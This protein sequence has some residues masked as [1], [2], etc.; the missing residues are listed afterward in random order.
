M[1]ETNVEELDA[2]ENW[3]QKPKN[4]QL[5]ADYIKVNYALDMNM[6]SFDTEKAKKEYLAKIRKD[7][8]GR[9]KLITV[10][11]AAA[12]MLIIALASTYFL[13]YVTSNN[14][15]EATTPIIV[16]NQIEPGVN[17][18]TLTLGTGETIALEKGATLR[19]KNATSNGKAITY[20]KTKDTTS[21]KIVYNYLTIPRGGQFQ[22]TL[23]DGTQVWLNS[24]T[25]LK[26]PVSFTDGE[27]RQV[28]LVY[29]EAYFS[30]S[31]STK[32][33]GSDFIVYT[34]NQEVKVLGTEFNIKAYK[35][36]T[37]IYTTLV[38]GKV[39]V[40]FENQHEILKPGE[41]SNVNVITKVLDI[42]TV[43]VYDQVS[44]KEGVFSFERESL[45]DIMQ[46]LSRWYDMQVEFENKE[47]E[48][49][50]FSGVLGKEQTIREILETLK[51]INAIK[52]YEIN[53]KKVILK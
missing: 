28:E 46:V 6:T 7:K 35:D 48:S 23:S 16:N 24:E 17:K 19:T 49:I 11:Y 37:N 25:R 5:F 14:K 3:L 1:H 53:K 31:P 39:A 20:T 12:A 8:R 34:N 36:E 40:N 26:Y 27:S 18:A 2:L 21:H 38:E 42:T 50:G 44:W 13:K 32:H 41:Q 47:L 43:D 29:G 10:R 9:K 45:K 22:I 4:K 30:V 51:N 33:N 15:I 52:N